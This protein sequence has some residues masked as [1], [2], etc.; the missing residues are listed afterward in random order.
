MVSRVFHLVYKEI[1]GLH[2]AA[3]VLGLFAFGSQLLA[4]VRDRMLAHI[5]GAG[6]ELDL[7]YA[8]FRI[9]DLLF[10]LFASMLS[11]YILL[12]F[13][14]SA[15]D[16]VRKRELLSQV[17]TVFLFG[18]T[19]IAALLALLAPLYVPMV[20]PGYAERAAE[21]TILLQILLLQPLF[22]GIS[23][24]CGV[25]TQMGHRFVLY[26]LSPIL[27][28]LGII[29]GIAALY[30]L[31]GLPGLVIGVVMGAVLHMLVQVPFVRRSSLVF[32]AVKR[33]E[34]SFIKTLMLTAIPRSLTLS[35]NQL[36]L[37]LFVAIATTFAAGSVSVLQFAY[38]IQ[39]VPLAVIGMS[40]SVAAFPSLSHL[41]ATKETERFNT[42]II[43]AMRHIIF[44]SVPIVGLIVV[45][46]AHIVRVLLG[47]GQFDWA[48]TR[49]TAAILAVFAI[50]LAAQALL[51]LLVR[52][53]YAGGRTALPLLMTICSSAVAIVAAFVGLYWWEAHP[54]VHIIL[55]EVMRLESLIGVEIV[56]LATA[57]TLGQLVQLGLLL[58]TAHRV[59]GT[60]VRYI[61][62]L[63]WRATVASFAGGL[64]AYATLQFVVQGVNQ[65]T[66]IGIALQGAVAAIIGFFTIWLVYALF[67]TPELH[68]INRS[69]KLRLFK[70]DV[71][72][73][74]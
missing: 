4:I 35:L 15:E 16:Q 3:Y 62:G 33:I 69:F 24:I 28:N 9:P 39:S 72:A 43:T 22:L 59:F 14:E 49:L 1:K 44:W 48:D 37:L 38:N 20:F 47:S 52:A 68:E 42:Q 73:K 11:V 17:F 64:A 10:V 61:R 74:Q 36:V 12:P 53:L 45:L 60:P 13:V 29:I 25:V 2:Q 21:L 26:A 65:E 51:L 70:T 5:F 6:V 40:Y 63:A 58:F 54:S 66:F 71:I 46:R 56:V 23:S 19:A 57:Y 8:A 41:F 32:T 7:Y 31:L 55:Q 18:Y 30:P 67:K 50:S 34:W 27:Y